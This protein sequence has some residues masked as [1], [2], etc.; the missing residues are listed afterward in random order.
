M[1]K[2]DPKDIRKGDSIRQEWLDTDGKPRASEWV[3]D[4]DPAY[5]SDHSTYTY[6]LLDR[7]V[8]PTPPLPTTVNSVVL[9]SDVSGEMNR[10]WVLT[11]PDRWQ[12][13]H[14]TYPPCSTETLMRYVAIANGYQ[15]DAVNKYV[16]YDAKDHK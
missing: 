9:L 10:G 4:A 1:Q 16:I 6:Y 11:A 5:L 7:P 2:I 12:S 8:P 13:L 3:I 15:N 14:R